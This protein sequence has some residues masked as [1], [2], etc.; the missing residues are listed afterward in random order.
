MKKEI[1]MH[2]YVNEIKWPKC[3]ILCLLLTYVGFGMSLLNSNIYKKK[4]ITK[5][6]IAGQT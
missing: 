6:K 4:I 5:I 2:V 1:Y 3:M